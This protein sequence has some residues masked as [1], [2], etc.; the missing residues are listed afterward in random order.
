MGASPSVEEADRW[1]HLEGSRRNE[2]PTI[3][4]SA[5]RVRRARHAIVTSVDRPRRAARISGRQRIALLLVLVLLLPVPWLH[6]VSDDPPGTA[7]RLDGRLEINGETIDPPGQ[8]SWL[9]VGRPQLLGEVVRDHLLSSDPSAADLRRGPITRRPS[10][11]EPAAVAVGLRHAGREVPLG[12]LIEV[13][14]PLLKGYP[15]HGF[16]DAVN[17]APV[18]DRRVWDEVS[19][20]WAGDLA[21][22]G[23]TPTDGADDAGLTFRF[24]SGQRYSAPGPGLP[25]AEVIVSPTAPDTLSAGIT[26]AATRLLPGDYFRNLSLGSSHGLMV[27]LMAYTHGSGQ[28]LA[29]GRHIAG[30]GGILG[31]GTVLR[32]GGLLAKA[33]AANRAGADVLLVPRSQVAELE[34]VPLPGTTVVPVSSLTDAIEWLVAP[35]V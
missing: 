35:V 33:Q 14:D 3:H 23:G 5:T 6:V 26:F 27:A 32:I 30:T 22:H 24:R 28:D 20:S 21:A 18:T 10:L 25:Y 8:W 19:D 11:S 1:A 29:Q 17:G 15:Q 34:D 4:T 7:W 13:R 9:A 2:G 31:D 12:V 16:L